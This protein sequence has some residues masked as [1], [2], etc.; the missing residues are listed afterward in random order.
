MYL[1]VQPISYLTYT[2]LRLERGMLPEYFK[3]FFKS[4]TFTNGGMR[5][6]LI[7]FRLGQVGKR[8]TV[9]IDG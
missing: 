9:S 1:K 6:D 7:N 4:I 5:Y 3:N 2:Y 8:L